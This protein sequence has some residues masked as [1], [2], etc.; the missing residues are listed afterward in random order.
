MT[1]APT[2]IGAAASAIFSM[3]SPRTK[4]SWFLRGASVA[5]VDERASANHGKGFLRCRL[6]DVVAA[7][8]KG[9][10]YDREDNWGEFMST[11]AP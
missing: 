8:S 9:G 1:L 10:D 5:P 4:T 6:A 11:K 3:R 2:G 7:A